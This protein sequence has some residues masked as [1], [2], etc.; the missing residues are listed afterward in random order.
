MY[1]I[2]DT[3]NLTNERCIRST[4]TDCVLN[5]EDVD[6]K[7]EVLIVNYVSSDGNTVGLTCK[8]KGLCHFRKEHMVRVE[9]YNWIKMK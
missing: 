3:V 1:K 5:D 6:I 2:G 4:C 9:I 8:G 7:S